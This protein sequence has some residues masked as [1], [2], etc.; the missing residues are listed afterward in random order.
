[1][2]HDRATD[3][4]VR[5]ATPGGGQEAHPFLLC[6]GGDVLCAI[7]LEAVAETLR[8]LAM[9]AVDGMPPFML[10]VSVIRGAAVP[11]VDLTALLG[12]RA[13]APRRRLVTLKLGTRQVGLAVDDV[14]G[15]RA[16]AAE[17]FDGSP[18]LLQQADEHAIATVT[19]LDGE[20]LL[21]LAHARLVPEAVWAA[22][23][24]AEPHT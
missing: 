14:I 10:G 12:S 19:S 2:L 6:R 21:T 24:G 3:R 18:P 11:I 4:S 5:A 23:D 22:I 7:P 1:M 16:I 17:R 8:P 20:L 9:R 13:L 15:V